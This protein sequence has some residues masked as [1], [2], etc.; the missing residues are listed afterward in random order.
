MLSWLQQ[1]DNASDPKEVVDAARDHFASYTPYEIALLPP[2]C[3]PGKLRD[4]SD[5]EDLY[6][7]AVEC[8]RGSRASGDA[9][10]ILQRFT[11]FRS[12]ACVRIAELRAGSDANRDP[13][14]SVPPSAR[15]Q[16]ARGQ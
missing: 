7:R 14:A 6:R 5:L 12:R 9:L 2:D 16:R 3:R 1:I 8:Y 15:S 13:E 11:G 4:E 10:V